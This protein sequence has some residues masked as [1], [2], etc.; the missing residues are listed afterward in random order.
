M[1]FRP[2]IPILVAQPAVVSLELCQIGM[3]R[4]LSGEKARRAELAD[5]E[6]IPDRGAGSRGA[7]PLFAIHIAT[8]VDDCPFAIRS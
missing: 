1:A 7:V 3:L 2:G 4:L 5:I 6:L 8:P